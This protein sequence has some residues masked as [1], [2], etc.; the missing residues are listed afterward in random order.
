MDPKTHMPQGNCKL[1]VHVGV[2]FRIRVRV[3]IQK[4]KLFAGRRTMANGHCDGKENGEQSAVL[5]AA[6]LERL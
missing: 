5:T 4:L 2:R 1:H 6:T 3:R